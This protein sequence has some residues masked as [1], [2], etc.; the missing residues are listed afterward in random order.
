M[1]AW[2]QVTRAFDHEPMLMNL[3]TGMAI[4]RD[5]EQPGVLVMTRADGSLYRIVGEL[6]T[7]AD[8]LCARKLGG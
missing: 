5:E 4:M 1:S 3:D 6:V 8:V 2:V 7:F